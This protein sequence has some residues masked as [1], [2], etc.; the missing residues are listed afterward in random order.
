MQEATVNNLAYVVEN[1]SLT[2]HKSIS[3]FNAM[4]Y[5]SKTLFSIPL[6]IDI[7]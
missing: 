2:V 7:K 5:F 6:G 4:I 1:I 3:A